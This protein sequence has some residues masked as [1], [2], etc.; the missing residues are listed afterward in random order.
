MA[1]NKENTTFQDNVEALFSGM[2]RFL[3]TKAVVGEAVPVGDKVL[4]YS[5]PFSDRTADDLFYTTAVNIDA[6]T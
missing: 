2:D 3:S 4:L 6:G 5:L 1:E